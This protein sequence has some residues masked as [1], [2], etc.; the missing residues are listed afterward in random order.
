MIESIDRFH[1]SQNEISRRY[2]NVRTAMAEHEL[3]ALVVCGSEYTGFEGAI[4]YLSGFHILHRY[5][6]VVV[7]QNHEAVAVFPKE[8]T[9][10]GDHS[11]TYLQEKEFPEHC[12]N[13][14]KGYLQNK[15]V[16]RL[17][18]YGLDYIINVRDF[19]ALAT[20]GFEII[21][22]EQAFD[23]ARI[24]KS[25]EEIRSVRHSMDLCK[26]G[27]LDIIRAYEPGKTEAEL[28]GEAERRF[29]SSGCSRSTMN[30]VLAGENGS[31]RP[32]VL[33]PSQRKIE[34]SDGLMYG[35]EIAGEGGHWVEFS[36]PLMPE[37]M[38]DITAE[39]FT[40]QQEFHSL[41]RE[42]MKAGSTV[43]EVYQ[44][45]TKPFEDRGYLTGHVCGHSIGMTMIEM[46]RVAAGVE[47]VLPENMVCSIHAHTINPERSHGL[48]FQET[49]LVNNACA[50]PLSGT[51]IKVYEGTE[52]ALT[53]L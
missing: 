32:Q 45:C 31:L 20:G 36:R 26:Q 6:Y 8:A 33:F 43:E 4:R 47:F 44:I 37:G 23:Y 3:D 11:S 51:A 39:M 46:P 1:P 18:I 2:L 53:E 28:M 49:Y 22:F 35:L 40:A 12:G 15:G 9:W 19:S 10:V 13:W 17:G 52:S 21:D 29:S 34:S 48:L 42:N 5:A 7:T 30:M 41:V 16:K 50:E 38:D 14:I 24:Q 25:D 27:V